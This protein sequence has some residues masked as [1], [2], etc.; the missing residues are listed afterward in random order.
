MHPFTGRA[1]PNHSQEDAATVRFF[2][3]I[4]VPTLIFR[5]AVQACGRATAV[6]AGRVLLDRVLPLA[7]LILAV[8]AVPVM[9]FSRSGFPRLSALRHERQQAEQ[10]TQRLTR[11]IRELRAAVQR[12][13]RD[14]AAVEQV[15]RDQLGLVRRTEVVFQFEE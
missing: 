4:P 8:V 1:E 3:E 9:M 10:E 15:G 13:R 5:L 7:V 6:A 14:P 12:I 2:S 11:E